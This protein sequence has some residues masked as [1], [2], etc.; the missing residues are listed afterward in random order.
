MTIKLDLAG[1]MASKSD[2][3]HDSQKP[4]QTG[5]RNRLNNPEKQFNE[6]LEE[7]ADQCIM[8]DKTRMFMQPVK[9]KEAPDYHLKIV[10]PMDLGTM[11]NKARRWGRNIRITNR[12][13]DIGFI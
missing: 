13:F 11:K 1:I 7:I 4:K 6:I 3:V 8:T 10:N 5:S 12:V 9:K 2:M